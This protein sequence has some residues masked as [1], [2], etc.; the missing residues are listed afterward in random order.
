MLS[1]PMAVMNAPTAILEKVAMLVPAVED[2]AEFARIGCYY[3]SESMLVWDEKR[4]CYDPDSTPSFGEDTLEQ[5]FARV[6]KEGMAGQELGDAA[7]F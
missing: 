7:L 4:D 1:L 5:F 2:T 3:A 6:N